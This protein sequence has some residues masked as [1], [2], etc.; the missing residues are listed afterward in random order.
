MP[1]AIGGSHR[2]RKITAGIEIDARHLESLHGNQVAMNQVV[3][4]FPIE[5]FHACDG[6]AQFCKEAILDLSARERD[7]I[8]DA[9]KGDH[10]NIGTKRSGYSASN[11]SST[12]S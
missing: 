12:S 9:M 1:R 2:L 7:G 4:F 11:A 5:V 6:I 10:R 3:R 8:R